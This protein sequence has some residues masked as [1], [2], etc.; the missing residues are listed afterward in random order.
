MQKIVSI[1]SA[2]LS[3]VHDR[4]RQTDIPWT[5]TSIARGKI[6]FSDITDNNNNNNESLISSIKDV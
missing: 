3:T 1:F 5:V 4:D 6:T 2:V